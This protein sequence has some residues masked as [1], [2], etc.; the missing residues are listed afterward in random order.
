MLTPLL[1][2]TLNFIEQVHRDLFLWILS[3]SLLVAFYNEKLEL[4][5]KSSLK[6]T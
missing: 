2:G 1:A 3:F 4:S 5:F 6:Q